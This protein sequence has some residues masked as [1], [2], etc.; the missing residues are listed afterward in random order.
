MADNPLFY[1][2]IVPL[3]RETHKELRLK[4]MDR[5]YAFA[6]GSHMIPALVEEFGAASRHL[7]IVFLMGTGG[8]SPVFIVG[9]KPGRNDF[10]ND[11]G[12]WTAGYIPAFLRR[13]PFMFGEVQGRDPV[14]CIDES[15]EGLSRQEGE[16]LFDD[17][18]A[19][20]PMLREKIKFVNDYFQSAR[21]SELLAKRIQQNDLLR[22]ISLEAKLPGGA[23][24]TVH[25]FF[26]ID[27]S[28]LTTLSDTAFLQLRKD[29]LIGP[30]YAH[31]LS[32]SA[33]DKLAVPEAATTPA[34]GLQ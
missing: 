23:T 18:G 17:E 10:V 12:R 9:L 16:N 11:E 24:T 13:Y 27:E 33:V 4:A 6:E 5:P 30:L 21:R 20:T 32:L 1:R 8:L 29:G 22:A 26:A 7:P 14:V 15:Y 25:G 2:S 19:E 31:L 28:K 34:I 3:N